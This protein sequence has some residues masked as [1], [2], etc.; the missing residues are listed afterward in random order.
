MKKIMKLKKIHQKK[1]Q[2]KRCTQ[3][4]GFSNKI[5][6][7]RKYIY[8]QIQSPLNTNEYLINNH[9]SPF[10]SEEDEDSII[11][12]P[13]SIIQFEEDKKTEI[14]LF[15]MNDLNSTNDESVMFNEKSENL[16]EQMKKCLN[17]E[18]K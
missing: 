3:K 10:F 9:S 7:T 8:Q 12:K 2:L 14:E 16:K 5:S 6:F 18:K 11:I 13:I 17:G 4:K 15:S 1:K